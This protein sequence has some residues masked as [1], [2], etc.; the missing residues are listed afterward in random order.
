MLRAAIAKISVSLD[1]ELV[2]FAQKHAELEDRSVSAI[3]RRLVARAAEDWER[4]PRLLEGSRRR[5][6]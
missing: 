5:A 1:E 2:R 3:V 4:R 6:T